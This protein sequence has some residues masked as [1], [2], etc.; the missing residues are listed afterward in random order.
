MGGRAPCLVLLSGIVLLV[1]PQELACSVAIYLCLVV[2]RLFWPSC[3]DHRCEPTRSRDDS[4]RWPGSNWGTSAPAQISCWII[5]SRSISPR[6]H[7]TSTRA[8]GRAGVRRPAAPWTPLDHDCSGV[9]V[10]RLRW[11]SIR[12]DAV[13]SHSHTSTTRS[14][15]T[16]ALAGLAS[17]LAAPTTAARSCRSLRSCSPGP[18][19]DTCPLSQRVVSPSN[20]ALSL[21]LKH[22][23]PF[24]CFVHK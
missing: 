14:S 4:C 3:T 9:C 10:L 7:A 11:R 17:A 18:L 2:G 23:L 19:A 8:L 22:L 16:G 13:A 6:G 12:P 1:G 21:W 15:I 24:P 20:G 5:G